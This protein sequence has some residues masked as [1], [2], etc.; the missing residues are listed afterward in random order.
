MT[1]EEARKTAPLRSFKPLLRH[2]D[3]GTVS[4][5]LTPTVRIAALVGALVLTG[6]AAAV[7]LIGRGAGGGD[8]SSESPSVTRQ[9]EHAPVV[10]VH[11]PRTSPK[12]APVHVASG[13]PKRVD[14]ALRQRRVVIVAVGLPG[15]GVDAAVAREAHAAAATSHAGFVRISAANDKAA[16]A[17]VAKAGVLPDPAVLVVKRPGTV[18]A[19]FSVTDAATIAQAVAEARG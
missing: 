3:T 14:A 18:V 5:A 15:A 7:F 9:A 13:F 17:L 12:H 6:L 1:V 11:T 10:R 19:T 16:A 8:T 2:A 4:V